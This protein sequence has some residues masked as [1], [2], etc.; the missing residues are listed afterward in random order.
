MKK[1]AGSQVKAVLG[2]EYDRELWTA[3][4]QI[5]RDLGAAEVGETWEVAGSQELQHLE[6]TVGNETVI[7]EGETY[8]GLSITGAPNLVN[9]ITARLRGRAYLPNQPPR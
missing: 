9:A 1:N 7:V 8:V 2:A 3:V 6:V 5:L 4:L